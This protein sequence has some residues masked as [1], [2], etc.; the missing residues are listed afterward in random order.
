MKTTVKVFNV[1]PETEQ[2][3][4]LSAYLSGLKA[5]YELYTSAVNSGFGTTFKVSHFVTVVADEYEA[6]S[7]KLEEVKETQQ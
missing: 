4:E 1:L 5:H 3:Q 7:K 2:E 6:P